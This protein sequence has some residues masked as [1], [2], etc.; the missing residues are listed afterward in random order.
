MPLMK[1]NSYFATG[2][3]IIDEQ[4]QRLVALVNGSAT[5][6]SVAYSSNPNASGNCSM[7]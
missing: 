5:E 4:H 6:L 2:I 3:P 7:N 1:W